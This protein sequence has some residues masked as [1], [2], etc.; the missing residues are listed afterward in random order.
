MP[1]QPIAPPPKFQMRSS[2]KV[3]LP[4]WLKAFGGN[5][6]RFTFLFGQAC[7]FL[8]EKQYEAQLAK[9]PGQLD[10]PS[11]IPLQAADR[12]MVQGPAEPNDSFIAR[13]QD[14]FTA[15]SIAG[16]RAAVLGQLQAYFTNLHPGIGTFPEL[17]IVGGNSDA[18]TWDIIYNYFTQGQPPAHRVV[19]PPNWDFDGDD[20]PWRA[21]LILYMHDVS[22]GQS[23]TTLNVSSKGGSGVS[24]VTTGFATVT[25]MNGADLTQ[26]NVNTYLTVSGAASSGNNGFFQ[27]VSVID[28]KSCIIAN[29]AAVAPDANNGTITYSVSAYPYI[30][31][32]PVW[33][34]PS[35]VWGESTW[36]V[37]CSEQVIQSLR[38]ILS[39]WK[40]SQTY[41]PNIIVSFR[42]GGGVAGNEFSPLSSQGTGNPNG[43]WADYGYI[44]NG[45]FVPSRIGSVADVSPF[46]AFCDGTGLAVRCYEKNVT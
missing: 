11:F 28:D 4:P 19:A 42:G 15:W 37:T 36:G 6:E 30:G 40:S 17:A 16:S 43:T 38:Q 22:T 8:L 45:C 9:C 5:A 2:G 44:V 7:D 12:L 41:Y 25:N 10:D 46:T 21:W 13:L 26:E 23:G 29:P 35:F 14:A 34:S 39:R 27:I 33:G 20:E 24:G 18:S 1:L 32:G 3:L 31:P